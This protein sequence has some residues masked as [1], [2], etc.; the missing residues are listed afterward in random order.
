MELDLRYD[1]YLE[2]PEFSRK[3]LVELIKQPLIALNDQFLLSHDIQAKILTYFNTASEEIALD[4]VSKGM[5]PY[6]IEE[7]GKQLSK[8]K[9]ASLV[10]ASWKDLKEMKK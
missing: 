7:S 8:K 4:R 2:A 6:S 3:E 5:R 10:F 1:E 9:D